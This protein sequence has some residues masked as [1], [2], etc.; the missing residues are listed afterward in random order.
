MTSRGWYACFEEIRWMLVVLGIVSIILGG[1]FLMMPEASAIGL[2]W[3]FGVYAIVFGAALLA[4]CLLR[5]PRLPV[6]FSP[7]D[8]S[9]PSS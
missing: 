4:C 3:N 9:Q 7:V 6:V 1:L 5:A 8:R 2:I